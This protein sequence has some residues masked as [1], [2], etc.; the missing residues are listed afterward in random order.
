MQIRPTKAKIMMKQKQKNN[1]NQYKLNRLQIFNELTPINESGRKQATKVAGS[2]VWF[3]WV[4]LHLC[5]HIM[6]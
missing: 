2:L 4:F 3:V 1:K 6:K 5:K